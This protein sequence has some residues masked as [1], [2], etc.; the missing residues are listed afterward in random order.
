MKRFAEGRIDG[1][2][3]HPVN[4]D[5]FEQLDSNAMGFIRQIDDP[6]KHGSKQRSAERACCRVANKPTW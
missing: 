3:T 5:R 1:K 4:I 2:V 6:K